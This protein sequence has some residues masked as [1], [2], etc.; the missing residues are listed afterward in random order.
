M[1]IAALV[2]LLCAIAQGQE[3]NIGVGQDFQ[4]DCSDVVEV[5]NSTDFEQWYAPGGAS[6]VWAYKGQ[7]VRN[8]DSWTDDK[9]SVDFDA[10]TFS[11]STAGFND[12]G[13]YRCMRKGAQDYEKMFQVNVYGN[14]TTNAEAKSQVVSGEDTLNVA[15]CALTGT[16]KPYTIRWENTDG[17]VVDLPDATETVNADFAELVDVVLDLNIPVQSSSHNNAVYTC[18]VSHPLGSD[19]QDVSLVV[20]AGPTINAFTPKEKESL[21]LGETGN[22]ECSAI[23]VPS[24]TV[25]WYGPNNQQKTSPEG[26]VSVLEITDAKYSDSGVYKCIAK[27]DIS[28]AERTFELIVEG[29]P[30]M[31][32]PL[33]DTVSEVKAKEGQATVKVSCE[34]KAVPS[35]TI[36]WSQGNLN[37]STTVIDGKSVLTIP[38]KP[39]QK[40]ASVNCT[41]SNTKGSVSRQFMVIPPAATP[42]SAGMG[43]I[44]GILIAVLILLAVIFFVVFRICNSRKQP[45]GDEECGEKGEDNDDD[46]DGKPAGCCD[47]L[48]PKSNKTTLVEEEDETKDINEVKETKEDGTADEK[49]KLTE[50]EETPAEDGKDAVK[51]NGTT[52]HAETE[53]AENKEEAAPTEGTPEEESGEKS[54]KKK[55]KLSFPSSCFRKKDSKKDLQGQENDPEKVV[56][57]EVNADEEQQ[58]AAK[59]SSVPSSPQ[60]VKEDDQ[61]SG[62]GDT[63]DKGLEAP[64]AEEVEAK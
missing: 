15:T 2:L 35:P 23:A 54:P 42:A 63:L 52:E 51:D 9:M 21:D 33:D 38:V 10:H 50:A 25:A 34:A 12:A 56:E 58:L 24:A 45:V 22:Y 28:T 5:Q 11:L 64:P 40:A 14:P 26:T 1:K 20:T 62:K 27:N 16:S 55:M 4:L 44:I 36:T 59:E 18:R 39:G 46:E 41:A 57:D 43:M 7:S 29:S 19:S 3:V 13:E 37:G 53:N 49:Q 48:I 17:E 61:D 8:G 6:L 30:E 32:A 31:K 60:K 47:G